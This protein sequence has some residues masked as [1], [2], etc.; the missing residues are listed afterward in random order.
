MSVSCPFSVH[1]GRYA[2]YM[3][4][5]VLFSG[6]G[7]LPLVCRYIR[8]LNR[9]LCAKEQIEVAPDLKGH[10]WK[11]CHV[12]LEWFAWPSCLFGPRN[13]SFLSTSFYSVSVWCFCIQLQQADLPLFMCVYVVAT[14]FNH[15]PP[16]TV[17]LREPVFYLSWVLQIWSAARGHSA[18]QPF[19]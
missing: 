12:W 17:S 8:Y 4:S 9:F 6:G 19:F 13:W 14:F 11:H 10:F 18:K 2:R 5:V 15:F 16:C 7:H 3:S 1:S